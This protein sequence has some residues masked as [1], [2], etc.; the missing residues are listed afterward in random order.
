[1]L[2]RVIRNTWTKK[3]KREESESER[4]RERERERE[5]RF[6]LLRAAHIVR[7]SKRDQEDRNAGKFVR[8]RRGRNERDR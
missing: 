8:K 2:A 6:V 3:K 1:L 4:E 7:Q 5:N